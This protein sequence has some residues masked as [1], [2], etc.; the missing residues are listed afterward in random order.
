[1]AHTAPARRAGEVL[2]RALCRRH[3]V[4]FDRLDLARGQARLLL[5]LLHQAQSTRFGRDHDFRRIRTVADYRRLVPLR[6][7]G[8]LWRDYWEHAFPDLAG[9]TWPGPLP[10]VAAGSR[11]L[12][13]IPRPICLSPALDSAYR[14][15]LRT[16]LALAAHVRPRSRFFTGRFLVLHDDPGMLGVDPGRLTRQRVP[17]LLRP[18]VLSAFGPDA[19]ALAERAAD[20]GVTCA[21]GPAEHLM[22]LIDRVQ[23]R[24]GRSV[25]QVWPGLATVLYTSRS[26]ITAAR[27]RSVVGPD[28]LTLEIFSRPEG[29]LAIEDPRYGLPRLLPEH[30]VYFELVPLEELGQAQPRRLGLDEVEPGMPVELVL[31]SPAGLWACRTG[32]ALCLEQKDPPLVRF[33]E[34]PVMVA[35]TAALSDQTAEQAATPAVQPPHQPAAGTPGVLQETFVHSPWSALVD[36]G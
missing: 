18:Y 8:D 9:C 15:T 31:T 27:L 4:R 22:A 12:D 33:L 28:V 10:P 30:G 32:R 36:R 19:P 25:R 17:V 14:A 20:E 13:E 21:I 1:L 6:S 11:L 16:A 26:P 35:Q 3:L 29:P 23:A 2:F 7:R 5:G 24:T 34:A